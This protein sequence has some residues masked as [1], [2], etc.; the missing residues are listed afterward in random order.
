MEEPLTWIAK[1]YETLTEAQ[2]NRAVKA[3]LYYA[4]LPFCGGYAAGAQITKRIKLNSYR[5]VARLGV[6]FVAGVLAA[7]VFGSTMKAEC[8]AIQAE[9]TKRT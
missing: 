5:F 9:V 8:R 3:A 6:P 7:Q 2:Q 4:F 1:N